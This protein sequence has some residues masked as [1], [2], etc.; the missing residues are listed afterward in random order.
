[1]SS[2]SLR[3]GSFPLERDALRSRRIPKSAITRCPEALGQVAGKRFRIWPSVARAVGKS[4]ISAVSEAI[5]DLGH[6]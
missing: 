1:M 2:A 5:E 4:K 6:R 3:L